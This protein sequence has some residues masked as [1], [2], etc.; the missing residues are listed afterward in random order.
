VGPASWRSRRRPGIPRR[1]ET[2]WCG[3]A[4]CAARAA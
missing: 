4:S 2:S 3:R 1:F